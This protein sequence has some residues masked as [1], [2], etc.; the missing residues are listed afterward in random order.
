M[1]KVTTWLFSPVAER[2]VAIFR[3]VVYV[4][5][6]VDVF[7]TTSWVAR[8]HLVPSELYQP[9]FVGRLLPLPTPTP[10]VVMAVQILLL[11]SAALAIF[12]RW[13]RWAGAAVFFLYLEWMY[14]AMSYGKVDHDRFAF[15]V[16]LA[17]LPTLR[18]VRL[19]SKAEAEDVG[20]AIHFIQI[21]VVLTY[22]LA[23][24]AKLRFGGI[25][26]VNGST[27]MRAVLRRGT[28]LVNPL[29]ADNPW[30]LHAFQYFI[31]AFELASP[32]ML[33]RNRLGK[34]YVR[35]AL[36]FHALTYASITI[37]FL[38]HVVCILTFLELEKW[39]KPRWVARLQQAAT[40]SG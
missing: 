34:A 12:P 9:L 22:F 4:F 21:A 18:S 17:V 2:R 13:T 6:F 40:S 23:A 24:F 20:W 38:P 1:G 8:H 37:I 32:V 35:L 39:R 7:I 3:C 25:E 11:C 31:V 36:G 5:I 29:A 33:L 16:A 19:D 27:L 30:M 15:L 26:W 14:I 28:Y 10:T